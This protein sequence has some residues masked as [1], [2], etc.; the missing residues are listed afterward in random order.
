MMAMTKKEQAEMAALKRQL[1]YA[2]AVHFTDPVLP[3]I[4]CP[5]RS[6]GKRVLTEGWT[7]NEYGRR[8]EQAC[9]CG[10]YHGTGMYLKTSVQGPLG[11]YSSKELALRAM[12]QKLE[13]QFAKVLAPLDQQISA[14]RANPHR[15]ASER[16]RITH[17]RQLLHPP[18]QLQHQS[19]NRK[20]LPGRIRRPDRMDSQRANR[21]PR[22]LLRG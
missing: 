2:V 16:E 1:E 13:Q 19:R 6:D 12:R 4:P 7:F 14:E 20:G 10:W 9:S 15:V 11:L 18:R 22:R 5:E 21:K 8:V 3:D 17:G